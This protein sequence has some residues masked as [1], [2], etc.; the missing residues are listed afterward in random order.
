MMQGPDIVIHV[1]VLKACICLH[2][3][4]RKRYPVTQNAQ[5]DAEDDQHN[6]VPGMKLKQSKNLTG[7]L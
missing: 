4:M 2:N 3:L 5:L 6:V 7:I 1:T